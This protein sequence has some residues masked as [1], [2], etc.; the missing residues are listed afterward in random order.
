MRHGCARSI[1]EDNFAAAPSEDE[2]GLGIDFFQGVVRKRIFGEEVDAVGARPQTL[3]GIVAFKDGR[4]IREQR[5]EPKVCF[6]SIDDFYLLAR[7][8]RDGRTR[9]V[10]V[11]ENDFL[12]GLIFLL[13]LKSEILR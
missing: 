5:T 4:N 6:F 3:K 2:D 7:V 12:P 9:F 11:E 1:G 10:I 8:E 13:D